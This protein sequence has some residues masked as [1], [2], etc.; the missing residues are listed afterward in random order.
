MAAPR[1]SRNVE[2]SRWI[3]FAESDLNMARLEPTQGVEPWIAAFHAQQCAEKILKA[4]LVSC[5]LQYP[6]THDI[7][8]LLE[9]CADHAE[10]AEALRP[11]EYLTTFATW[12]RYPGPWEKVTAEESKRALELAEAVWNRVTA[13]FRAHG[14]MEPGKRPH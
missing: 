13:E 6:L 10:W 5:G 11:A 1:S 7:A 2:T 8:L 12:S 3:E 9:I 4:F 14:L